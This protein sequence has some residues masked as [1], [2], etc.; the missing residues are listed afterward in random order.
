MAVV[1]GGAVLEGAEA[2]R[3]GVAGGNGAFRDAVDAI[4]VEALE[5]AD[6]VPV[7]LG[8]LE[9]FGSFGKGRGLADVPFQRR[10]FLTVI[11]DA[12]ST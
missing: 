1:P 10:L 2:V 9:E 3:E 12:V 7:D 4:V 11:S 5:L 6:A 8:G